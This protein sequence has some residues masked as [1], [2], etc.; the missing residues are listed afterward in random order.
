MGLLLGTGGEA[1]GGSLYKTTVGD[2]LKKR[3][4]G[5]ENPAHRSGQRC[6]GPA[7]DVRREP[8]RYDGF[9]IS[10]V[11][12]RT[13]AIDGKTDQPFWTFMPPDTKTYNMPTPGFFT[14]S[15][16]EPDFFVCAALGQ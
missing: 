11:A 13:A 2:L 1:I 16:Y 10:A 7:P 12:T 5:R 9:V 14:G 15:D 3:F 6:G 4:V 8:R